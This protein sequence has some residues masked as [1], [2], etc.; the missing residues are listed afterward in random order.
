MNLISGHSSLGL[1]KPSLS[2]TIQSLGFGSPRQEYVI[3]SWG[4]AASSEITLEI[5]CI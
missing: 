1:L 4:K 2:I 3:R 5:Q